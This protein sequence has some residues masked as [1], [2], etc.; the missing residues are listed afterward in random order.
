[1]EKSFLRH[2]QDEIFRKLNKEYEDKVINEL[3]SK[4]LQIGYSF[5]NEE[6]FFNFCRERVKIIGMED[7]HIEIFYL[8]YINEN[9]TGIPLLSR[10]TELNIK[11]EGNIVTAT[12]G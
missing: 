8:D 6:D 9:E 10:S 12:Y 11:T 2:L 7:S 5:N 3:T 4:L 1:M